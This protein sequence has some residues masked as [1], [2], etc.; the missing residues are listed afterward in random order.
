MYKIYLK[1][2]KAQIKAVSLIK[3]KIP[4]IPAK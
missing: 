2:F 3:K 4:P 1:N